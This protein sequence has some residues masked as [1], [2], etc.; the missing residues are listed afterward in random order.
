MSTATLLT[1]AGQVEVIGLA[2]EM[3]LRG[4][5]SAIAKIGLDVEAPSGAVTIEIAGEDKTIEEFHG[6][7]RPGEGGT[8]EGRAALFIVGGAGALRAA[9]APVDFPGP[10]AAQ[11][12]IER[13]VGDAGEVLDSSVDLSGFSL[14]HWHVGGSSRAQALSLL[15]DRL[16]LEWRV[17][18]SGAVWIGSETWASGDKLL[19]FRTHIDKGER[20]IRARPDAAKLRPGQTVLEERIRFVA[21]A[22]SGSGLAAELRYGD[23]RAEFRQA[24]EGVLAP[25]LY[26]RTHGGTVERQDGDDLLEVTADATELGGLSRVPFRVGIPGARVLLPEGSRVRLAFEDGSPEQPY[27]TALDQDT[28]AA[29]GVAC[30]G[31]G[32]AAGE[33]RIDPTQ[34][35]APPGLILSYQAPDDELPIPWAVITG[36][37]TVAPSPATVALRA[38]IDEGST[39]VLL[40]RPD[41]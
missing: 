12:V 14:N 34:S 11:D 41:A 28:G 15:A 36:A 33:L 35:P 3:S 27:A 40:R 24:L 30:V 16:G 13:L 23:E 9:P 20:L 32:A 4:A 5:W 26:R 7:V 18:A 17:L 39:R 37:V 31:D 10:V 2:L 25:D 1:S 8:F 21:L 19:G 29:A 6:T 22:V 38:V